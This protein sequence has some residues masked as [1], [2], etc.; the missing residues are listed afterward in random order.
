LSVASAALC[1]GALISAAGPAAGGMSVRLI[2]IS[3]RELANGATLV[4]EAT[5]PVPYV[6]TR[7]DPM[8]L[9]LDLRNVAA[10]GFANH[11]RTGSKSPIGSVV[12]ESAE[13]LGAPIARIRIALTQPVTHRVRSDR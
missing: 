9:V 2:A 10:D 4:I 8:T 5:E 11:V 1:A 13:S 12:V 7:P 6:A 3:S